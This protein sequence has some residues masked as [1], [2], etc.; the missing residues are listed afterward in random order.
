MNKLLSIFLTMAVSISASA[1]DLVT[2]M[3][4]TYT[5]G[6]TS[7][8]VYLYKFNQKTGTSRIL[9]SVS[10]ANP[11][12]VVASPDKRY[13]YAVSEYND[14]RQSVIAFGFS[15]NHQSLEVIDKK[16]TTNASAGGEDPC[17]ILTNGKQVVTAN[18]SGGDI[19]VFPIAPDGTL[20][21]MSQFI[22]F[23]PKSAG[24][25]SHLHC[26]QFSPD[27]KY[28]FADDLGNDY[29]YRFDVNKSADALN[30]EPFLSN[31]VIAYK[32]VDGYGPR[33]LTFSSDGHHAYL[34]NEL[35]DMLVVFEYADG[36]LKPIQTL[37]AYDGE[38]GGSA[39]IHISPDGHYLYTSHR[40]KKDGVSIFYIDSATGMVSRVG[41]QPTGKHPRNFCMT[42]NGK[43]LLVACRDSNEIQVYRR[44]IITGLLRKMPKNIHLSKPVCINFLK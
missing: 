1:Q 3:V 23:A 16:S 11:S 39:D 42:P 37:K 8:G 30:K 33:H 5:E 2:M 21:I 7:K 4:G 34:I 36:T 19:S 12:Y 9:S 22:R 15:N 6:G 28:L 41:Y 10:A 24:L 25:K 35:G 32:G 31:Q 40:L 26:V 29:I 43:Y 17:Y 13:A 27:G 20:G 38:G 18:Y 14:G 44:N